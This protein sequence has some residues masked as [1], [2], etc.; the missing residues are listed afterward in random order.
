M[1]TNYFSLRSFFVRFFILFSSLAVVTACSD[2]DDPVVDNSTTLD[3]SNFNLADGIAT[4]GGKIW[5]ETFNDDVDYLQIGDFKF[6]H[7][8]MSEW[9]TWY[10]FTLSNSND[11]TDHIKSTGGWIKNQWG[12]M[13]KG[14]VD[15]VGKPFLVSY[16]DHR[17]AE[18]VLKTDVPVELENFS[19][20]VELG[21][22]NSQF[23][24]LS[25]YTALSPWPYY[26]ILNGDSFSRAFKKGDYF[27]LQV[28]GLDK[29]KKLTT[30]T[31]VKHY[32]VDFREG[33]N[34][35][36]TNWRKVDLRP[37]GNVKY[38]LFFL[39]TTDTN[40]KWANTALYFTLDKLQVEE[41]K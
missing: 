6:H 2:N 25:L 35:I 37:L 38:L 1:N 10:G 26:G 8:A 5:K 20:F 12:T 7:G 29:D 31:P 24:A 40:G 28:Y 23:K 13:P 3:L 39:E 4:T 32:F 21:K 33:V 34:T 15:G 36:N 17:P 18:G 11:N 14:G 41:I 16:A 19:S 9:E 30:A 22:A 27:A